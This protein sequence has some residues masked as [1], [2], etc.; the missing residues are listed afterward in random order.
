MY[1]RGFQNGVC[2]FGGFVTVTNTTFTAAR[3]NTTHFPA[4]GQKHQL[5]A[6]QHEKMDLFEP[7]LP[8][9]TTATAGFCTDD[10]TCCSSHIH[11]GALVNIQLNKLALLCIF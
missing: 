3:E 10:E 2:L 11:D 4:N 5:V 6:L 9:V 8:A 7:F 1:F